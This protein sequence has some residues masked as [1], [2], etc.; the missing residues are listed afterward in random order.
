MKIT[1]D[2]TA[3]TNTQ[4]VEFLRGNKSLLLCSVLMFWWLWDVY[5]ST[6]PEHATQAKTSESPEQQIQ[7]EDKLARLPTIKPVEL[8]APP[9]VEF[10]S[11][12][13]EDSADSADTQRVLNNL[14]NLD[15]LQI[16]FLLP[17]TPNEKETFLAHMYQCEKMQFGV[18]SNTAPLELT[19]LSQNIQGRQAAKLSQ[20]LRIAHDYLTEY[21]H[22][23]VTIY[24]QNARPVRIFPASIDLTLAAKIAQQIGSKELKSFSARYFLNGTQVGLQDIN[25]NETGVSD[26]W[27][28]SPVGCA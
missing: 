17:P 22:N 16:Q 3:N 2:I 7:A 8:P 28:I 12:I 9:Q 6:E 4:S 5:N 20:M 24:A 15:A 10:A 25:I 11:E 23:L 27:L 14:S 26:S 18:V 1:R 13:I 19:V 21:E